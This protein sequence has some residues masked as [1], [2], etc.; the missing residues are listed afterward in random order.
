MSS[1]VFGPVPSRRLGRSLG[2]DLVP[3]KTCSFDC[4]YCQLGPT[5][6]KTIARQPYVPVEKV[7]TELSDS[8]RPGLAL[9]YVTLSG[10]GEPTLHSELG[11]I[12]EAI[13]E[14]TPVPVAILTNGSLL[15][16]EPVRQACAR[17]DLVLPTLAG[18]D[19]SSF[20]TIHRPCSEL[21]AR[22]HIDGLVA[23]GEE[24]AG[25]V[26]LEVFVLEGINTTEADFE[27][28]STLI[29]QI[30][31]ARIQ[32]NTAV[33]PTSEGSAVAA[34]PAR[35]KE[36]ATRLGRRAEV[37]ADYTRGTPQ[38]T[39]PARSDAVLAL[40]RRRPCTSD[41]VAAALGVH[42][43]EAVKYIAALLAR[44]SLTAE[45]RDGR[46]YFIAR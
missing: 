21:T 26:W 3:F 15:W 23:F 44:D 32:L 40:C 17:A 22:R 36:W 13:K 8:L 10:S 43:N 14:R 9:D 42:R 2:V 18:H 4:V 24:Y 34:P 27:A 31:P 28:L 25:P 20:A 41:D 1:C 12:V 30:R 16:D 39:E 46:E 5:T 11:D 7:I 6:C 37:I 29:K 35:L 45:W 38:A 19:S 33:R